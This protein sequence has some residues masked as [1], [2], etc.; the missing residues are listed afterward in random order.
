MGTGRE[1]WQTPG[2]MSRSFSGEGITFPYKEW[3]ADGLGELGMEKSVPLNDTSPVR[4]VSLFV[5]MRMVLT[6]SGTL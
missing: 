6:F 2:E 3:Q 5:I 1:S 4:L